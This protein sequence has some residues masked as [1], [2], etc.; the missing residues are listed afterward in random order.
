MSHPDFKFR[1]CR[2]CRVVLWIISSFIYDKLFYKN[3][4]KSAKGA[5]QVHRIYTKLDAYLEGKKDA[6]KSLKSR[7]CPKEEISD[8]RF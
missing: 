3:L 4:L 5:T 7:S 1:P 6:R 8:K 2:V